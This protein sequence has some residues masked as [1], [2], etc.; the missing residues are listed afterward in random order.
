MVGFTPLSEA[1]PAEE[2]M[3]LLHQLFTS[4]DEALGRYKEL[5][6][7]VRHSSTQ[8]HM[9][10]GLVPLNSSSPFSFAL[11]SFACWLVSQTPT[12]ESTC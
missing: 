8:P 11:L 1:I 3:L 9:R 10:F 12:P 2:V 7:V 6:K 4:Y 5:Y